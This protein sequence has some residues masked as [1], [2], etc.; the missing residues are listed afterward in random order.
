MG[1]EKREQNTVDDD[2]NSCEFDDEKREQNTVSIVC[3]KD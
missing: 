2:I 3:N 1:D